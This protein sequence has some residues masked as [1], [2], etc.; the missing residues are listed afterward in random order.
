MSFHVACHSSQVDVHLTKSKWDGVHW[1]EKRSA[2]MS[3]SSTLIWCQRSWF[4]QMV[5]SGC[6]MP[7]RMAS[8][9]STVDFESL[10][11]QT[12]TWWNAVHRIAAS[13][14]QSSARV[15]DWTMP[16][17]RPAPTASPVVAL[18][19]DQAPTPKTLGWEGQKEPSENKFCNPGPG[20]EWK[21]P[22]RSSMPMRYA[23][24]SASC[25]PRGTRRWWSKQ[26]GTSCVHRKSSAISCLI[27]SYSGHWNQCR[28]VL[29]TK[30][31]AHIAGLV[32]SYFA[33]FQSERKAP[34]WSAIVRPSSRG[35]IHARSNKVS[36]A[37]KPLRSCIVFR[38]CTCVAKYWYQASCSNASRPLLEIWK[39]LCVKPSWSV[40]MGGT[41]MDQPTWLKSSTIL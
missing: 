35:V 32:G 24:I 6:Q 38:C 15:M 22:V 17:S 39:R 21:Q 27:C 14:P 25:R 11:R 12:G 10:Q 37:C 28:W 3:A 2:G 13:A 20:L 4:S 16:W 30:H 36:S 19:N 31:L 1:T 7:P 34:D 41:R 29:G 23:F 33:W 9:P 8:S 40:K 5:S 26:S 18:T